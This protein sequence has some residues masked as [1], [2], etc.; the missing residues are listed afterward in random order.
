MM[1]NTII[2]IKTNLYYDK[3][4][5]QA[6]LSC[7]INSGVVLSFLQNRGVISTFSFL[8]FSM[9]PRPPDYWKIGKNS[10]LYVVIWRY[11]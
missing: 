2:F 4:F 8:N 10:T 6:E 7:F 1:K 5:D 11:S 9:P 3:F